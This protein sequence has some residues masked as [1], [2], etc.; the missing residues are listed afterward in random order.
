MGNRLC[1]EVGRVNV[2][3]VVPKGTN[4]LD[5]LVYI[6][7]KDAQDA[8]GV[9]TKQIAQLEYDFKFDGLDF[10]PENIVYSGMGGSALGALLASS[11][12]IKIPFII[13]RDYNIPTFVSPKTLFVA[14][15]YSGNTEETLQALSNA[16][17]AGAYIV[18]V[19]GGG[20]LAELAKEKQYPLLNLP[21]VSQ[22]RY[23]ALY[24]FKACISILN[25]VKALD[26][27]SADINSATGG[28]KESIKLWQPDVAT[29]D[30]YAKQLALD[31]VGKS[32]VIYGSPLTCGAAYKWK[33]SFN[34]NAKTIAW[35]NQYPEFSHNEFIGWS[36]HPIEKPYAVIDLHSTF[37]DKRITKRFELS[38]RLLSGRRPAPITV[39]ASGE[40]QLAQLLW[41]V[42]LGD[43]VSIYTALLNGV[44]PTPVELIE[45]F[46]Q[47]LAKN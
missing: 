14:S 47:E 25:Q 13:S 41:L 30:N 40:N 16:E 24:G 33:I 46:K 3:A 7:E 29:K 10:S 42:V 4:M 28:L 20:R 18:V 9:A 44:N 37:D 36:G 27:V 43:F 12:P 5:D 38:E 1:F 6:H 21:E 22:P 35:V 19:A 26:D 45:K 39:K 31:V 2:D 32:V 17:Q 34:E 11:L 8:L 23:A 15:S